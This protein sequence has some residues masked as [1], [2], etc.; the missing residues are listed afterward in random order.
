MLSLLTPLSKITII[1]VFFTS[2]C[3]HI[4]LNR[5]TLKHETL[6]KTEKIYQNFNWGSIPPKFRS[7]HSNNP[8]E[9]GGLNYPNLFTF[10]KALKKK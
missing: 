6:S 7:E 4:K 9:D 10:D 8:A 1:K 5:S 2:K 3:V